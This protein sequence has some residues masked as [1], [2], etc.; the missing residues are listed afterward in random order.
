MVHYSLARVVLT[1]N[2]I[3]SIPF[4]MP[5]DSLLQVRR[6]SLSLNRLKSWSDIHALAA[7]APSLESLTLS[8]NPIMGEIYTSVVDVSPEYNRFEMTHKMHDL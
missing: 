8:G 5:G 7:W 3:E 6:L 2:M 4:P 1:N